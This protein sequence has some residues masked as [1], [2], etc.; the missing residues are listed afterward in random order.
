[1]FASYELLEKTWGVHRRCIYSNIPHRP[2][3]QLRKGK[4]KKIILAPTAYDSE[5]GAEQQATGASADVDM[6]QAHKPPQRVLHDGTPVWIHLL[7]KMLF[8][9]FK[10]D[11]YMDN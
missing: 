5:S 2:R 6:V 3:G 8:F 1:M 9:L 10:K 4:K 11:G 7:P